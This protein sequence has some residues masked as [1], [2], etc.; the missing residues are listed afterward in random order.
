FRAG[1]AGILILG[2][3]AAYLGGPTLTW[4]GLLLLALEVLA[5]MAIQVNGALVSFPRPNEATGGP[6][7]GLVVGL[8]AMIVVSL[9]L[10]VGSL[11]GAA[12]CLLVVG[13][14]VPSYRRLRRRV[15]GRIR[16]PTGPVDGSGERAESTADRPFGRTGR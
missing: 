13:G 3:V 2:A 14:L 15:L 1:L 6:V 5:L 12:A 11:L 4:D 8:A 10:A 7:S 16:G 9:G